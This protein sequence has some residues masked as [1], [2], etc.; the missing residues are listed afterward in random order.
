MVNRTFAVIAIIVI[1]MGGLFAA[2]KARAPK[3][4]APTTSEIW[5]QDGVPVDT[6]VVS[7]GDMERTV[8]VTGNISALKDVTVSAKVPG[9]VADVKVREGDAVGAGQ[10]VVTLDRDDAASQLESAHGALLA[11]KAHVSQAKTNATVTKI[12][13]DAGIVKAKATLKAAQAQLELAKNP[14]RSQELRVAKNRVEEA[15]ATLDNA[16]AN[17]KRHQQLV[18]EGAISQSTFDLVES[19]YKVAKA[20]YNSAN[21]QLSMLQEGG[22]TEMVQAAQAAVELAKQ[23]LIEAE[24]NASQNLLR[25][26]DI[27]S[28][29]AGVTQAVAGVS[30]AQQQMANTII[31]SPISGEV[32]SRLTEPGQVVAPGQGLARIVN[33]SSVYFKG[34]VSETELANVSVGDP[35][36]VTIDAMPGVTL[37]GKVDRIFPAASEASRNFSVR[38]MIESPNGLVRPGMF[39][40][41]HIVTGVS[42]NVMLIPK[43]AV[44]ERRGT[45]MV[46]STYNKSRKNPDKSGKT[47]TIMLAK[48]HDL[49]IVNEDPDYV[50]AVSTDGL[51][52]G[53]LVVTRGR[54]NLT[55]GSRVEVENG[56]KEK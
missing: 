5:Q 54:Q 6:A 27:K 16:E 19:Q 26:E 32:A 38:I 2:S 4:A 3:D 8:E 10:V 1:I 40:R 33:V 13:T 30:L 39:A 43:D 23:Q 36:R 9:R 7:I 41:G 53:D 56:K 22:R 52:V 21:D 29:G 47:Q 42:R 50:Q 35:V 34:D 46:F 28:A 31:R 51:R 18:K 12:Q 45:K 37:N 14:S 15:K 20:Q 24:A 17:Y 11:A 49:E 55:D 25:R 44:E 48:R